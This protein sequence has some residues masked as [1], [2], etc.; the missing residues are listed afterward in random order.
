MQ[1]PLTISRLLCSAAENAHLRQQLAAKDKHLAAKDKQ[2]EELTKKL[3]N[4]QVKA[5]PANPKVVGVYGNKAGT[6]VRAVYKG[7]RSTASGSTAY[8]FFQPGGAKQYLTDKEEDKWHFED[9]EKV[10]AAVALHEANMNNLKNAT[11][12]KTPME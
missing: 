4:V 11:P 8:Y 7:T 5:T 9:E 6:I 3:A 1:I 2:I 12:A 10:L